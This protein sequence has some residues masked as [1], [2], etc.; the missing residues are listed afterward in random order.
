MSF[1]HLLKVV[2]VVYKVINTKFVALWTRMEEF[3]FLSG[4][5]NCVVVSNQSNHTIAL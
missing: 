5:K 4:G 1:Y 3:Y 2:S